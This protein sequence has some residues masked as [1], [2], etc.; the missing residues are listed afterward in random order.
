MAGAEQHVQATGKA[1]RRW[2]SNQK[3]DGTGT[4]TRRWAWMPG[5]RQSKA[6]PASRSLS[7]TSKVQDWSG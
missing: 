3:A 6:R 2:R 7:W 4:C 1:S 5:P